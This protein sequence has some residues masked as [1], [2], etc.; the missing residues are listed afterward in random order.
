[1][2]YVKKELANQLAKYFEKN[3]TVFENMDIKNF[4]TVFKTYIQ[5]DT[6]KFS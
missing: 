6:R 3:I 1:M 4:E 2:E 5:I